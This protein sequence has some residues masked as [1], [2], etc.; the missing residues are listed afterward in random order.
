MATS[1][2]A[3]ALAADIKDD[4]AVRFP[5]ETVTLSFSPVTDPAEAYNNAPIVTVGTKALIRIDLE[6]AVGTNVLGL[7]QT[8]YTP[9]IA[10]VVV[11]GSGEGTAGSITTGSG[12]VGLAVLGDVL[13]RGL[14]T[15]LYV[16]AV[17]V[18]ADI[19]AAKLVASFDSLKY[20]LVSSM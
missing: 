7:P 18:E 10:Q 6:A 2:K 20:P 4:L 12:F 13:Q 19:D 5:S 14:K 16:S 17:V 15:N 8:V 3:L 9:H 11:I 1:Q